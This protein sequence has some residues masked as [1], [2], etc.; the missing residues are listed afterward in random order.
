MKKLLILFLLFSSFTFGQTT[1]S[2]LY[3]N[4][5]NYTNATEA[6]FATT[7]SGA[8][9]PYGGAIIYNTD[10]SKVRIW[11]G[12]TF[13]DAPA[14]PVNSLPVMT[15]T[16]SGLV[17]TPPNNTT[18]FLRGDGTFAAPVGGGTVTNVASADGSITVTNPTSTVDLAVVKSPK[19]ST[20]RNLAGN[21]VDGSANVNF[22]NKF[23]VQGTADAGLSAAQFLGA[24]GTGIV[25]NTTTTGVLSIAV[26]GDFPTL[27]QST[28]GSAATLTTPRAIMGTNFDGSAAITAFSSTVSLTNASPL[29]MTN[30]QVVT[31]AL[32]AQTIGATTLTIPDFA[33]VND[34]FTFK[35]KSQTMS[36]KT[37]VAPVL[38]TPTSGTLTNC[39]GYTDAHLSI[40]DITTNN[41]TT[42]AHGFVPKGTN[43]GN[44]LRD[45][46]TWATV[47]GSGTVTTVSVT[48]A[49]GVSGSVANATTTPAITLTLGAITPTTVNSVTISGSSTPT[50]SVTGTTTVS[51]A[52]T[53]DQTFQ[54]QLGIIAMKIY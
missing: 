35:T 40:S 15:S 1:V 12:S 37:F 45:D 23:I 14:I 46:G 24:L 47:S 2:P 3:Q 16:V 4:L 21:S 49:N 5:T 30:G 29:S 17:P 27:N 54:Q 52:N 18:T 25:K 43:V 39:T 11:N 9:Y 10:L 28:T 53:G 7:L 38:G 36:N 31:L 50:L 42:S 20:A 8:G 32:T 22:S 13:I 51:G 26:A 6:T 33:N 34:E 48:T 44:F 41:F 19:W